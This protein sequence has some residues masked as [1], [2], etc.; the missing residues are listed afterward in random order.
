MAFKYKNQSNK[1]KKLF[2]VL[3][4]HGPFLAEPGLPRRKDR[5]LSNH[6][7]G[8]RQMIMKTLGHAL[9]AAGLLTSAVLAQAE[10]VRWARGSDPTSLDPHAFNVGTNFVLLHQIYETSRCR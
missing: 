9:L 5:R 3:A 7:Q 1:L 8:S 2:T 6:P 10:T 4:P